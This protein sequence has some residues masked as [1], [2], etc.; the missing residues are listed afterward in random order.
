[1]SGKRKSGEVKTAVRVRFYE[2][3]RKFREEGRSWAGIARY[4]ARY[5][6]FEIRPEQLRRCF[7]KIKVEQGASAG[8]ERN[9]SGD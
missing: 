5:H 6:A 1:M 4:L 8:R 7:E 2:T 9:N 3:V